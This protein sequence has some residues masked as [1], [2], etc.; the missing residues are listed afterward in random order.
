MSTLTVSGQN[1]VAVELHQSCPRPTSIFEAQ[2]T[3]TDP[4]GLAA[5]PNKSGSCALQIR[6]VSTW[7][8]VPRARK[9]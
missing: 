3:A 8:F 1:V 4:Q 9:R 2:L 7:R 5:A 6:S